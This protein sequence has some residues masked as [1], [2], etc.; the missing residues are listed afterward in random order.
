MEGNLLLRADRHPV[1]RAADGSQ[2]VRAT[3]EKFA[4]RPVARL[5]PRAYRC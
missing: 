4:A 5:L 2:E 3:K 1:E